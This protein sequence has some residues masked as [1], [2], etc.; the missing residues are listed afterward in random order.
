MPKKPKA[1]KLFK[2]SYLDLRSALILE[3]DE[4]WI[5]ASALAPK[6]NKK[7]SKC[8]E[9]IKKLKMESLGNVDVGIIEVSTFT[10]SS[11]GVL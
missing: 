9:A 8:K 5:E 4:A 2:K 10:T 11:Q 6:A 7:P 3:E 1:Q